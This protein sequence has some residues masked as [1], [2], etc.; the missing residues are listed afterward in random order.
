MPDV[1]KNA[2]HFRTIFKIWCV[3]IDILVIPQSAMKNWNGYV[4]YALLC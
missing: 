1:R 3:L 4:Q 2:K